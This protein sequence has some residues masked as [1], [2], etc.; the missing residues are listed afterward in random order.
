MDRSVLIIKIKWT[1]MRSIIIYTNQILSHSPKRSKDHIVNFS[2]S[3]E[4]ALLYRIFVVKYFLHTI[5]YPG[6][7]V[8]ITDVF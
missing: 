2:I 7:T 8:A 3:S 5:V 6:I 4:I 1:I